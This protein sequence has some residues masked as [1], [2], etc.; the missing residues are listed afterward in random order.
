M[1]HKTLLYAMNT[2]SL[3]SALVYLTKDA[4]IFLLNILLRFEMAKLSTV[5]IFSP[6]KNNWHI[7][8]QFDDFFSR[9]YLQ[10]IEIGQ[11]WYTTKCFY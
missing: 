11:Y 9:H 8:I 5:V 7:Y 6:S 10:L 4:E 2:Y 1:A 3:A